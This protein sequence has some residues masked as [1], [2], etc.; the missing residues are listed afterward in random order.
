MGFALPD[1]STS[2]TQLLV[3]YLLSLTQMNPVSQI[4]IPLCLRVLSNWRASY[5]DIDWIPSLQKPHR[6]KKLTKL[7]RPQECSY[8]PNRR[9]E[10]EMVVPEVAD[11]ILLIWLRLLLWPLSLQLIDQKRHL[12]ACSSQMMM[13][14]CEDLLH[15]ALFGMIC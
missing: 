15:Q 11:R 7:K 5:L 4:L 12:P 6:R 14:I 1:S 9:Q 13:T 8:A 3:S 10:I 2:F